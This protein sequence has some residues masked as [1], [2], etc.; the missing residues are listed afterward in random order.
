MQIEAIG[1]WGFVVNRRK[2]TVLIPGDEIPPGVT[3]EWGSIDNLCLLQ[4]SYKGEYPCAALPNHC[5]I[6]K[7][8]RLLGLPSLTKQLWPELII[9]FLNLIEMNIT[10]RKRWAQI[11]HPH[12]KYLREHHLVDHAFEAFCKI[13]QNYFWFFRGDSGRMCVL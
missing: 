4:S 5:K 10:Y 11:R 9:I 13:K 12:V 1:A 7:F 3:G 2:A 6:L 8:N